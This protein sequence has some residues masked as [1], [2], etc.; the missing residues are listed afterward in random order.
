MVADGY[1]EIDFD[2]DQGTFEYAPFVGVTVALNDAQEPQD[3]SGCSVIEFEYIGAAHSF[4]AEHADVSD[5]GYHNIELAETT[6]WT[7]V[8]IQWDEL[9]QPDWATSVGDLDGSDIINFS[10][11]I[12]GE[13]GDAGTL[14]IDNLSCFGA[15][16]PAG[17]VLP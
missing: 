17:S 15:T 2:L 6:T 1:L 12:S 13:T 9:M 5:Y 11:Q 8:T 4:R 3:L 7:S 14:A 10:W 16:P